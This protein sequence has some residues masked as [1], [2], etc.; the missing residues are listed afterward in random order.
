MTTFID[1]S[2]ITVLGANCL[3]RGMDGAPKST[4]YGDAERQIVSSQSLKKAM[5]DYLREHGSETSVRSRLYVDL[6]SRRVAQS[7]SI[8]QEEAVALTLELLNHS[9]LLNDVASNDE[10]VLSKKL[11]VAA[12]STEQ[13][14]ALADLTVRLSADGIKSRDKSAIKKE[15]QQVMS[16]HVGLD[17][18]LFGT[19][20]AADKSFNVDAAAQVAYGISVTPFRHEFDL[21][22]AVDEL[23][24]EDASGTAMMGDMQY[25]S[26]VLYRFATVNV[27]ELAR[28]IGVSPKEAL[29]HLAAFIEA[30]THSLPTGKQ[31]TFAARV[32]PE[33]VDITVR[34][35]QPRSMVGAFEKAVPTASDAIAAYLA[36]RDRMNHL[37]GDDA[38]VNVTM[39]VEDVDSPSLNEAAERVIAALGEVLED[40]AAAQKVAPD[41]PSAPVP[42]LVGDETPVEKDEDD[43][44]GP[45]F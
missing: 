20:V 4:F 41:L 25:G 26:S 40:D 5:R 21:F 2:T 17:V 18:A 6:V 3:N 34:T 44:P 45:A 15:V 14:D 37:Y 16:T 1:I 8:S 10:G 7:L 19:M 23:L 28:N 42:T 11:A 30:F 36:R 39:S 31:N 32:L 27:E 29:V 43:L 33:F 22:T 24:P 38:L 35:N 9:G 13:L 12:Y